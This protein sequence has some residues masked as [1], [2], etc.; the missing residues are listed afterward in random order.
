MTK[1]HN[2]PDEFDEIGGDELETDDFSQ[3][4]KSYNDMI[5]YLLSGEADD[6]SM[7]FGD[8]IPD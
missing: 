8:N 6:L 2:M 3:T 7:E 1:P 4:G 5:Q